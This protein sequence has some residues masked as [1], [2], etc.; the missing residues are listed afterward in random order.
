MTTNDAEKRN[1]KKGLLFNLL[2]WK[3]KVSNCF[4]VRRGWLS[5]VRSSWVKRRKHGKGW[6]TERNLRTTCRHWSTLWHKNKA[7]TQTGGFLFFMGLVFS[8]GCWKKF[9]SFVLQ[10]RPL[11]KYLSMRNR[12]SK[13]VLAFSKK[14]SFKV[15]QEALWGIFENQAWNRFSKNLFFFQKLGRGNVS[16]KF[17]HREVFPTFSYC[18]GFHFVFQIVKKAPSWNFFPAFCLL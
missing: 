10:Q 4:S 8:R 15:S 18:F 9:C 11:E 1:K 5:G 14:Q 17:L 2:S 7:N 6:S 16:L 3:Q 12:Q 13:P